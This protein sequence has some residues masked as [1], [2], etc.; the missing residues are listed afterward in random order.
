MSPLS[1][2]GSY[3]ANP[4]VARMHDGEPHGSA[5]VQPEGQAE[6]PSAHAVEIHHPNHPETGDGQ[7]FHARVHHADGNVEESKHPSFAD[8][9]EHAGTS[10][11]FNDAGEESKESDGDEDS[12]DKSGEESDA[13]GDNEY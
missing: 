7:N 13:D 12:D 10:A 9:A 6:Q 1:K 4:A 2:S 5:G 8:A 3:H 11:G